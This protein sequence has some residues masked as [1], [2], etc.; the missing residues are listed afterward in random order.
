MRMFDI[1]LK[2]VMEILYHKYRCSE[3]MEALYYKKSVI[4]NVACI[5]NI[6]KT[7]KGKL[8]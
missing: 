2:Y 3:E 5:E 6:E 7:S 8:C 4:K 1:S